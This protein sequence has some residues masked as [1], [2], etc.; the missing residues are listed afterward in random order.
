MVRDATYFSAEKHCSYSSNELFIQNIVADE[1]IMRLVIGIR[2][3][4][5]NYKFVKIK[6]YTIYRCIYEHNSNYFTNFNFL[7]SLQG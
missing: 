3:F 4:S 7:T 6:I 2:I 5:K 1:F